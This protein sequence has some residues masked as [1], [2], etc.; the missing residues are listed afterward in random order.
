MRVQKAKRLLDTTDLAMTDIALR[1]GF[2][3][4]R[5]FNTVFRETYGRPPSE[6]R[7]RHIKPSG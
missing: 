3:S 6:I 2:R 1:A 5:R 7:R 4:L